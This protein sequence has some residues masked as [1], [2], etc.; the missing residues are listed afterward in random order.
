MDDDRGLV[1]PSETKTVRFEKGVR[2]ERREHKRPVRTK[3]RDA[4]CDHHLDT[5]P[6]EKA[7]M[8]MMQRLF[9][10]P[11]IPPTVWDR[12]EVKRAFPDTNDDEWDAEINDTAEIPLLTYVSERCPV[13]ARGFVKSLISGRNKQLVKIVAAGLED[14]GVPYSAEDLT[15]AHLDAGTIK[16]FLVWQDEVK[17][18]AR[19]V[20]LYRHSHVELKDG[21]T[22]KYETDGD[23]VAHGSFGAVYRGVCVSTVSDARDVPGGVAIKKMFLGDGVAEAGSGS[24]GG[25]TAKASER[26]ALQEIE[27]MRHVPPGCPFVVELLGSYERAGAV[28]IVMTPFAR[29]DLGRFLEKQPRWW[30]ELPSDAA[31]L[32]TALRWMVGLTAGLAHLHSARIKHRDVKPGNIL[33]VDDSTDG[34]PRPVLCDFGLARVV[35]EG[36]RTATIGDGRGTKRYKSPQQLGGAVRYGRKSDVFSTAAVLLEVVC[37]ALGTKALRSLD[38]YVAKTGE[39]CIHTFLASEMGAKH[40]T[41]AEWASRLAPRESVGDERKA[42]ASLMRAILSGLET[43]EDERCTSLQLHDAVCA[44]ARMFPDEDDR[45][46]ACPIE[47]PLGAE[48]RERLQD[49][50]YGVSDDDECPTVSGEDSTF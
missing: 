39:G 10:K 21:D 8:S 11:L 31:R 2:E 32:R 23:P 15:R 36:E 4:I 3:R 48:A 24:G 22:A 45:P 30:T 44:A 46:S 42:W 12:D 29:S 16:K 20:T 5:T 50:M 25:W 43:F 13:V 26:S 17:T 18:A 49:M 40:G 27:T 33:L 14:S 7:R 37:I 1:V 35:P 38:R 6:E 19:A 34:P 28:Y 47:S 41:G 9:G